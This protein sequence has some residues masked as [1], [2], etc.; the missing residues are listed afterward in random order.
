VRTILRAAALLLLSVPA[1]AL[2][3]PLVQASLLAPGLR[4]TDLDRSITFYRIAL[5]LVPCRTLHHGT[6]TEVMLCADSVSGRLTLILLRD[7]TPGQSPPVTMG[8][9][10][11]K[12]VLRVPDVAAVA[13]RLTA[14]GHAV[15]AVHQSGHGPAVLMLTDPDGYRNELVGSSLSAPAAPR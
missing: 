13:A 11:A 7:E 8:D 5:G 10:L 6:L 12:I 4:V 15:E 2:G 3:Q 9:G 14:A 1:T